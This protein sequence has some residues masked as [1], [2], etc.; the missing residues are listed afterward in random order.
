MSNP[1]T[2]GLTWPDVAS[3]LRGKDLVLE[4]C[5]QMASALITGCGMQPLPH[6]VPAS[7]SCNPHWINMTLRELLQQ[8]PKASDDKMRLMIVAAGRARRIGSR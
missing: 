7:S 5:S 4:G 1:R 6:P 3:Y 8:R 2:M